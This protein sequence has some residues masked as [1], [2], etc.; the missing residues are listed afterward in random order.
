MPSWGR[1]PGGR[2]GRSKKDWD[3]RQREWEQD[4][5]FEEI[6]SS[7]DDGQGVGLGRSFAGDELHFTG[8]DLGGG[9]GNERDYEFSDSSEGSGDGMEHDTGSGTA[10]QLALRDKEEVLVQRA[11]ERIRRAQ[12]L[13]KTNVKLTPPE[14]D[15]LERKFQN[16]AAKAK[17]PTLKTKSSGERRSSGRSSGSQSVVPLTAGRRKSRSGLGG[18]SNERQFHN[19]E[20]AGPPGFLVAGPDGRPIYAPFGYYPPSPV[21]PYGP[22]SHP[23]SRTGSTHSL[24]HTPPL[25]QAQTRGSQKRYFSVPEQQVQSSSGSRGTSSPRP[26]P[27]DPDWQPRARST[28]NLAYPA[29]LHRYAAY[30][31]PLPQIPSQYAQPRRNVSGPPQVGYPGLKTDAQRPYGAISDPSFLRR[32]YSGEGD[33]QGTSSEDDLEDDDE[34]GQGVHVDVVSYG[35]GYSVDAGTDRRGGSRAK[36]SRR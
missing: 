10:M 26:L 7:S 8:A 20:Q 4:K 35:Q 31:P 21:S 9:V 23:G 13:G 15:A 5:R 30:S 16:D 22:S 29:D 24:Q 32:E 12:L 28:S 25:P 1:P 33:Q 18:T 34:E 6:D 3:R 11:M 27:D 17:R 19:I 2:K 14:R 36:K